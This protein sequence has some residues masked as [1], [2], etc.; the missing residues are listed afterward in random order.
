MADLV[1]IQHCLNLIDEG[2]E[3]PESGA[4]HHTAAPHRGMRQTLEV[5]RRVRTCTRHCARD[6]LMRERKVVAKRI[7]PLASGAHRNLAPIVQQTLG[8]FEI[9][10]FP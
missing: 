10:G 3:F 1:C 9:Q 5:P 8:I 2:I 7:E 4:P 6:K